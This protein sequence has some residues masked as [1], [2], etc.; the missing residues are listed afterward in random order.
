MNNLFLSNVLGYSDKYQRQIL[1]IEL[2]GVLLDP[3]LIAMIDVTQ[4][5]RFWETFKSKKNLQKQTE[6]P[7]VILMLTQAACKHHPLCNAKST[8]SLW[9]KFT[10]QRSTLRITG[11]SFPHGNTFSDKMA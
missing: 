6:G 1:I 2:L 5:Y 10:K 8:P 3:V 4:F 7:T 11:Q 9:N